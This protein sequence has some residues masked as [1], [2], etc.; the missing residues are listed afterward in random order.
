MDEHVQQWNELV[1]TLEVSTDIVRTTNVGFNP[2]R[3]VT[4]LSFHEK[5]KERERLYQYY[6]RKN[7]SITLSLGESSFDDGFDEFDANIEELKN[8]DGELRNNDGEFR[9]FD[10]DSISSGHLGERITIVLGIA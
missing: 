9:N 1:R 4:H 8:K 3:T 5:E 6:K 7:E 10:D 2:T